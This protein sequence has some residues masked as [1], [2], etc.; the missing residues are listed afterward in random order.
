[1]AARELRRSSRKDGL[2][3]R[4][5]NAR[6]AGWAA[7]ASPL[8]W[9]AVAAVCTLQLW[10]AFP[11]EIIA[12]TNP[13]DQI[14]YLEM[15]ESIGDGDWLGPFDVMTLTRDVAYPSWIAAVHVTRIPLRLANELLLLSASL[16][17]CLALIRCGV[18]SGISGLVFATLALQPHG[19][20]AMRELLPSSF[21][22]AILI[23]SLAGMLFSVTARTERWHLAWTAIALGTLWTTRPEQPLIAV[24]ILAF[25]GCEF[26][27]ARNSQQ[28]VRAALRRSALAVAILAGGIGL[29]VGSIAVFNFAH[30]GVWR[31]S[32]YK[33]PGFAAANRVLLS[34]AHQNPR[35]LVPV[36]SDVR[37]RAYAVSPAFSALRPVLEAPSWARGV[38][39][40][41]DGVC[42]D[43]AGGYFRWIFREAVAQQVE[44]HNAQAL[45]AG[46]A[47]IA[48]ELERACGS[49]ALPC[50][51]SPS[52]FL[53]PYPETYFPHLLESLRR[54]SGRM[55]SSGG[56]RDRSPERDPPNLHLNW[57]EKFDR[58]ANRRIE[59]AHLPIDDIVVWA[60][61]TTDPIVAARFDIAGH[62]SD[63]PLE[64]DEHANGR[65]F[66]LRL[67]V[68]QPE[69][70]PLGRYPVLEFERASGAIT[71]SPIPL[72]GDT[73]EV[74]GVSLQT[75]RW[76][77]PAPVGVA[78][79]R[80]RGALWTAHARLIRLAGPVGV[81][82][83]IALLLSGTRGRTWDA[84]LV[85]ITLMG[86]AVAS[87]LALLT[88]VDASSFP[89]FSTRYIYP[90]VSLY[91]VVMILLANRA[92]VVYQS[93]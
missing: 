52:S 16:L 90:T 88:M 23:L 15:A 84:G 47:Q 72:L 24:W 39:C 20:L 44:E 31:T 13:Y 54:I 21:Y 73:M 40:N 7:S 81:V 45:D 41:L 28:S 35:R 1:M 53:H 6:A 91:S 66:R 25:G 55:A 76:D 34:I 22:A 4:V 48:H 83:L 49:G 67:E 32:D 29:V 56:V 61:A 57:Q 62:R 93:R 5:D 50:R 92:W 59:F 38:S 42:D 9:L 80:V 37:E 69:R 75:E 33:A 3:S 46:L 63:V 65:G 71:R 60:R 86:A 70:R 14:R 27:L 82:S 2:S 26:A 89:A 18:P 51:R 30:Y 43:L 10:L 87:R 58:V 77:Q 74:D 68:G 85:A 17:L 36:P 12:R 79:T 78:Q 19:A 8:F 11:S 64:V